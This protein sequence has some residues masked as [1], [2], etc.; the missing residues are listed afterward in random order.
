MLISHVLQDGVLVSAQAVL[1]DAV[2]HDAVWYDLLHPSFEEDHA[3][4]ALLGIAVPTREEM[5]EI[6]ASS[7]LYIDNGAIYVTGSLIVRSELE[8]PDITP[9]TFILAKGRL[10]TVRYDEP[11]S[12]AMVKARLGRATRADITGTG[13]LLELLETIIDRIADVLELVSSEVGELS[14]HIFA[15][16][17]TAGG[18]RY[19]ILLKR[20]GRAGDLSS[21]ARES[22]VSLNRMVAFITNEADSMALSKEQRAY[23]K[24]MVRDISSLNDHVGFLANKITFLLDATLGMV[25]LTQNDIIKLFS[26]MS[27]VMMPPT[28][29]ASIYGMNFKAMPELD[30]PHGYPMALVL[31]IAAA[32]VPYA[33]F[34]WKKWL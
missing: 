32:I 25:S 5:S 21:H 26:V 9:V 13:V 14:H 12:F 10:V 34:R 16:D 24:T 33:L 15:R 31:M 11:R 3:I 22:L 30:W 6:E 1:P 7:R 28:L 20:I 4:E 17:E 23:L 2:P 19:K 29:I 8:K 27:V 18:N